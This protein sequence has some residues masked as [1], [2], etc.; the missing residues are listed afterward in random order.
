[1]ATSREQVAA[2]VEAV[3]R[4]QAARDLILKEMSRRIV[5]QAE[6]VDHLLSAMFAGGHALI[7]GVPGLAKTTLVS[8]LA[9]AL[10]LQFSRIQF[11]PD[12]MPSDVT[13]TEVIEEDRAT[14]RR[15]FRFVRGPVFTHILLADE[16]NRTPPKTQAALLEAMQERKVTVAGVTYP[17]EP[18]FHV[19][20][21]QNPIEQEGTYPLPEAQLDRFMLAVRMDYPEIEDEV[22]VVRSTSGPP[23][24]PVRKILS[25][26]QI[27]EIQALV[28]R[29][30]AGDHV[31]RLAVSLVR[32]TR[33]GEP[34]AP[35]EIRDY[36]AW[37]AGPR[38]AQHLMLA[39]KARALLHGEYTVR[40]EDLKALAIP[41]LAHRVILNFHAEAERVHAVDLLQRLI[42]RTL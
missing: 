11:T 15:S 19:F 40:P 21:T 25:P 10:N 28:L 24:E 39:A 9:E 18:P 1:V 38:A 22:A 29:V 6:V 5:G 2:E 26:E 33:P 14:G 31:I 36:V 16:I 3:A 27:L 30:P 23:G 12:L 4:T 42:E 34:D 7:I 13:G 41:V 32:R 17:L 35:K 37:G 8:T 20:A